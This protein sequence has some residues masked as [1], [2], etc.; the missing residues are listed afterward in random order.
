[1]CGGENEG[2]EKVGGRGMGKHV[3]EG[4]RRNHVKCYSGPDSTMI[5]SLSLAMQ[6]LL[7]N[8]LLLLFYET[9]YH[10]AQV[11]LKPDK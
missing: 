4:E 10:V 5:Q 7:E 9:G 6:R 8:F 3:F 1:M 2:R 11:G